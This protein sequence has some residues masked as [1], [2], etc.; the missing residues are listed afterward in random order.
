MK[1]LGFVPIHYG[2]E[3]LEL[4][5][6]PLKE[7]CDKVY[8]SYTKKPSHG[9]SAI[10]KGR[11]VPCPDS[12][13]EIYNITSNS[14]GGKLI[15]EEF[16]SFGR[17][18][19]HR[20]TVL[21][22]SSDFDVIISTDSDEV[23]CKDT[24]ADGIKMTFDSQFRHNGT[25]NYVNF[26]RSFDYIVKDGY[27]PIRMFNL[28]RPNGV[29]HGLPTKIYHFGTCQSKKTMEYKYLCHGHKNELRS[30][31]LNEVYYQWTPENQIQKLHPV[32]HGLWNA[33]A[34]DKTALPDSIKAHPNYGKVLV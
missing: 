2:V 20:N 25:S 6:D 3:Y 22:H 34:F 23:F 31:W 32:A 29:G 33:E 14:L 16:E 19:D 28:K 10:S 17:E 30:D 11:S 24:L 12:R 8:V 26:W 4:C 15:W 5:L 7:F 27:S 9:H 18:C 13:D 21:K 1:I